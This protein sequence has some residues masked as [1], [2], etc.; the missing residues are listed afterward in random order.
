MSLPTDRKYTESHEWVLADGDVYAVG[1]TD[2]AQ[3]QLGDLVFVG[4]VVVGAKL[5]AGD[6]AGVVESVKAASDIYAPVSGEI[7]AFNEEL[8]GTP[9]LINEAA[10]NTW[11]Y[12]IKPDNAADVDQLLDA[13]GYE[14]VANS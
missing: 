5:K 12:K 9:N 3:E 11:I 13:A 14:A 4:D 2:T 10:F 7:V 1:I 8:E 6:T